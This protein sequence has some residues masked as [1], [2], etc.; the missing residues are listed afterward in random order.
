ML[1][2]LLWPTHPTMNMPMLELGASVGTASVM[3]ATWAHAA[4][5]PQSQIFGHTLIAGTNPREVALTYDDGPNDRCTEQLL[6][7]LDRYNVKAN[8]FMIGRFVRQRPDLARKVHA[9]GH[10]VGNHTM[11][12]PWLAWQTA[13]RIRE[14]LRGCHEALKTRSALPCITSARPTAHAARS[15]CEPPRARPHHRAVERHGR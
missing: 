13:R 9:A 5:R 15:C 8:F 7:V 10:L 3:A 2:G 14:E 6:E 4:L 11:T 1:P 12:H